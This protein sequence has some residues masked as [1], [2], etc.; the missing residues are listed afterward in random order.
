MSTLLSE[1]DRITDF[2]NMEDKI[3]LLKMPEK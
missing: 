1:N 3:V 2:N